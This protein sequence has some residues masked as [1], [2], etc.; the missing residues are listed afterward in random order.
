[1]RNPVF[2][3]GNIHKA[4]HLRSLLGLAFDHQ[5]VHVDEIQSKSPEEVVEH[6]VRQAYA[7]VGKPVFVDDFSLWFD[8]LDGLPGPFIKFFVEAK[9]GLENLCRIADGLPSRR[10]TARGYFG[11][12]D[13]KEVTIMHGEIK[14][15]IA[16]HPRGQASYAFGSDPIF[17]VDGFDGRAR[18]ELTLEEY[19]YV[20]R[21]VRSIDRIKEFLQ[22]Q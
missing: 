13:G 22:Q 12:Y 4:E 19:E 8:D 11:Y 18:S 7:A 16:E 6:K 21:T 14:G 15:V 5:S 3:T 10:A 17:C 9:N 1:M 2:I 20:Y